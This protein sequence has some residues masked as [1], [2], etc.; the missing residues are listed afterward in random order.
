MNSMLFSCGG[1]RQGHHH[2]YDEVDGANERLHTAAATMSKT[3]HKRIGDLGNTLQQTK[4]LLEEDFDE[5]V[6]DEDFDD[7]D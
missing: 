3:K 7:F 6:R 5:D 4:Q 1:M 2:L